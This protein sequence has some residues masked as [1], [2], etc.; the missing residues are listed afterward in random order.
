MAIRQYIEA[1][2]A[3]FTEKIAKYEADLQKRILAVQD[4]LFDKLLANVS[5]NIAVESGKVSRTAKNIK[6]ANELLLVFDA[7]QRLEINRE[8]RLFAANVLNLS[9]FSASYFLDGDFGAKKEQ[10][11]AALDLV[12]ASIGID[13]KGELLTD[14]YLYRLGQSA[15]IREEARAFVVDAINNGDAFSDFQKG[16][17][18]LVKGSPDVDGFL[19]RYWRQY[20]YDTFNQA[21]EIVNQSM[22]DDLGLKHFVYQ[23]SIIDT[24]RAFCKHKAGKVFSVEEAR[25]N[26]PNDPDLIDKKTKAQYRPLIDR[27]RYNCRHFLMYISDKTA[28]KLKN[29]DV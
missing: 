20:A 4:L 18:N 10:V 29:N 15:Q 17:R 2:A 5:E 25:K 7:V 26:W 12:R 16:F 9:E 19:V 28:K 24:T 1:F 6:K 11:K 22:A 8:L 21:H 27:G 23:G 14:G 3:S 13:A